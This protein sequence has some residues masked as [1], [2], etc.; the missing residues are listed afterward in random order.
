MAFFTLPDE[1][2]AGAG[3]GL[4]VASPFGKGGPRGIFAG[5]AYIERQVIPPLP[6]FSKGGTTDSRFSRASIDNANRAKTIQ[7]EVPW[8]K[9]PLYC[10]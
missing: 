6:S 7:G 1:M 5:G 2:D 9:T 10:L 8:G 4:L 3:G